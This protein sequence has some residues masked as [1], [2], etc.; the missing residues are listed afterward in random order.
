MI[1]LN[2]A[3]ANARALRESGLSKYKDLLAIP[4]IS[5]LPEH[6][7]D[8]ERTAQWLGAE[9]ERIGMERTEVIATESHPVVCA[10]W[11]GAPGKPTILVYGHYDVQPVDPLDEW[12]TPPFE[13]TICGDDLFARGAADMKGALWAFLTVVEAFMPEGAPPVNLRFLLDGDEEVGSPH[14]TTF[15]T[16]HRDRLDADVVLNLD[17]GIHSPKQPSIVYALRG[18]AYFEIEIRGPGHDLHSGAFGG[19]VH[20][21]IQVLCELVAG[22]HDADGRITLPGFYDSVRSL[23]EE[24]RAALARL[25][26]DDEAWRGMAGAPALWGEQ[27]YTTVERVGARPSLDLNGIVGGFIGEGPKTVLPARAMAKLSM[28]LVADQDPVGIYD[29]LRA[30]LRD[31]MPGTVTWELRELAH[32]PGAIMDRHSLYMQTA[33]DAL[34]TTFGVRPLFKRE[35]GSVPIVGILQKELGLDS[36]MM[37]F[38]LPDSGVHGP[39]EKQHLPTLFKGIEAYARFLDGLGSRA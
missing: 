10:E 28:R 32:G 24:E 35:G 27:G 4:S 20:N 12:N 16:G 1:T 6:R 34:E 3:L 30:Y 15:L 11:L 31:N 29:Q 19:S 26:F 38:C 22:M 21:P 13:P 37:G 33:H 36:I 5:A 25:P 14:M 23:D 8:V 17:G 2:H 7:L 39:N 18:L 9:L